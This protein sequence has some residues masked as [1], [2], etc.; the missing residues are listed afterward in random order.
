M[1]EALRR[2]VLSVTMDFIHNNGYQD[3]DDFASK[4]AGVYCKILPEYPNKVTPHDFLEAIKNVKTSFF[5]INRVSK[6]DFVGPLISR[7]IQ[8]E[9]ARHLPLSKFDIGS[10]FVSKYLEVGYDKSRF[11]NERRDMV[12]KFGIVKNPHSKLMN[13]FEALLQKIAQ[14]FQVSLHGTKEYSGIDISKKIWKTTVGFQIKSANDDI[15]EDKIRSQ[16][17]KAL[18]HGIDGFVWIYGRPLSKDVE[19]SIQAAY[20]HF[21]RVN[22]TKKM[23][24]AL[25]YPELLAEL[26]RK[27]EIDF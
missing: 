12:A 11:I 18:E 9:V 26:F 24:C 8:I 16:A 17:S 27:Y 19:A 3:I 21:A 25:I 15:S 13:A 5:R 22:E 10:N 1:N 20:H 6:R 23:Y 2:K 7:L 4:L 14:S